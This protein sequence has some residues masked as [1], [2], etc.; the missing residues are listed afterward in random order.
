[1]ELSPLIPL[2]PSGLNC[3]H[4][5]HCRVSLGTLLA[6]AFFHVRPFGTRSIPV[7]KLSFSSSMLQC[8]SEPRFC[9]VYMCVCV[10]VLEWAEGKISTKLVLAECFRLRNMYVLDSALKR[11][12][13]F[14]YLCLCTVIWFSG[15]WVQLLVN[16]STLFIYAVVHVD[17]TCM[18]VC[19]CVCVSVTRFFTDYYHMLQYVIYASHNSFHLWWINPQSL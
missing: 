11:L 17:K 6:Q 9:S 1:M 2:F 8:W 15:H 14:R 19:V 16:H 12:F 7:W 13:A 10:C 5:E 3:P 4:I 18:S